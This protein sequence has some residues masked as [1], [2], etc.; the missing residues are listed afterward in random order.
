[1]ERR[2]DPLALGR[3]SRTARCRR[4]ACSI[5]SKG[6]KGR[7]KSK[8]AWLQRSDSVSEAFVPL[9]MARTSAN[10][11]GTMSPNPPRSGRSSRLATDTPGESVA[12]FGIAH[13]S[14]LNCT[15]ESRLEENFSSCAPMRRYG[16]NTHLSAIHEARWVGSDRNEAPGN[17]AHSERTSMR[18]MPIALA[19]MP[20]VM[21]TEPTGTEFE[22]DPQHLP[23]S[24]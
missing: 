20:S 12:I 13:C 18:S 9:D 1:M 17:A 7:Q 19:P 3:D 22:S 21:L 5:S 2:H 8:P 6:R 14:G 15:H 16:I 4:I 24:C 11:Q 10:M 23:L